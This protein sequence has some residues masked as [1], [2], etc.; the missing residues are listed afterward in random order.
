M[1][2]DNGLS[3]L[4][5]TNY[6][7]DDDSPRAMPTATAS[8]NHIS[9]DGPLVRGEGMTGSRPNE[10][11]TS[12][13]TLPWHSR[14]LS[15]FTL[16]SELS[17]ARTPEEYALVRSR[18]RQEWSFNGG[19]VS[20]STTLLPDSQLIH[21]STYSSWVLLRNFFTIHW[22]IGTLTK[23]ASVNA[24]ILAITTD[25]IF[26]ISSYA[27]TAVSTSSAACGLGIACDVWFLLRYNWVNLETFIVCTFLTPTSSES[28][29]DKVVHSIV[30]VTYMIRT[31]PSPCHRGCPLSA[32]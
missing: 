12:T 28:H 27:H 7:L 3:V 15:P 21:H 4:Q 8:T 1:L 18:L 13:A 26:K 17:T 5:I 9:S 29:A 24:A 20:R 22:R 25:S 2:I 32:C 6:S 30:L 23:T 31:S 11:P 19:F 14:A 10:E 16:Y